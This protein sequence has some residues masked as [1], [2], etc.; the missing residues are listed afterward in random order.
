MPLY[1]DGFTS[2]L[3]KFDE[4]SENISILDGMGP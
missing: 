2:D 4:Y 3:T 1:N